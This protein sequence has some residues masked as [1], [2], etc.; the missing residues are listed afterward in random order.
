MKK[1]LLVFIG[2]LASTAPVQGE[3][4]Q[5]P[6]PNEKG[7]VFFTADKAKLEPNT[8][9]VQLE[10]NIHLV[11][12]DVNGTVRTIRGENISFNQDTTQI[13][14]VGP[15]H[16]EDSNGNVLDGTNVSANYTTQEFQADHLSTQYPPLRIISAQEISSKNGKKILRKATVTCCDKENPHYT[17]SVG[18]LS[19]SQKQ[20]IFGTNAV[21][22]LGDTPVFYVPVFWRSLDSQKP[23][24]TYV[25]FTQSDRTGFGVLTTSVFPEVAHLHPKLILDYYTKSGLGMGTELT[26]VESPKLRGSGEFY[27]IHDNAAHTDS[28]LSSK[29]RWGLQGGYWWEMYDSSDHFNNSSGALYQFQTQFRKVS[30]PYFYDS[31]FRSNPYIFM[32][33]QDTNFSF[34]RQT[35]RTTTRI[36]YQEKDIFAMDK[37]EFM[38][39]RR[40]LPEIKFSV[41]PFNDPF[42]KTAN[43]I[44]VD[45]NNTST[46]QYRDGQPNEEGPYRRQAHAKWT[47]EKSIRLGKA[48]TFLPSGFYDQT[49][50]F[51]DPQHNHKDSWVARVGTEQ[52]VRVKSFLGDTDVGYQFTK[53]LSTGTLS[54]DST[55]LDKGIERNRLYLKNYYMPSLSTYVRFETGFNLS[56]TTVNLQSGYLEEQ[57][58]AHLKNRI[59]PLLVE[60]GYYGPK[61]HVFLQ[62]MYDL[63]DKNIHFLAQSNFFLQEHT[64]GFGM[65]NFADHTDPGSLYQTSSDR[66]TFTTSWGYKPQASKWEFDVGLDV[67][68]Y[69]GTWHGFNKIARVRR[70][71]HDASIQ[72]TARDRNHNLS[73]AFQINILCGTGDR[74]AKTEQQTNELYWY[75]WRTE[76]TLRD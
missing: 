49:V 76:G 71:F 47:L 35:R 62:D 34:S 24:T 19:L 6:A 17:L 26:A 10:G 9:T 73:F 42:L 56:D 1:W 15:I 48:V 68:T 75:P 59:E 13:T 63:E 30:D 41:L 5:L 39:E 22:R 36:S 14:S 69:R 16:I 31:F 72:I 23:W 33:D 58:W 57:T 2:L 54:S 38:A 37:K 40:T 46:L 61:M 25:N 67:S 74:R 20:K 55:S 64:F 7:F 60:W 65:N 53:R 32:P 18:K 43:R 8:K 44:E 45:F 52:N 28:V 3:D 29:N 12:Q 51:D 4:H 70:D 50:T 11:Q 66:F 21:L 27:Y